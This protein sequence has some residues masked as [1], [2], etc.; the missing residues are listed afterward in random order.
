[1]TVVP[2]WV[3][4]KLFLSWPPMSPRPITKTTH[5]HASSASVPKTNNK[6]PI[7][8]RSLNYMLLSLPCKPIK[9]LPGHFGQVFG[10]T[11]RLL[12]KER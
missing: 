12:E 2:P 8:L 9:N 6:M 10:K 5:L 1:M 7:N 4:L 11:K 3:E